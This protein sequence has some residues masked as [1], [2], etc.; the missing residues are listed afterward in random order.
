MLYE[1][2][3]KSIPKFRNIEPYDSLCFGKGE[4]RIKIFVP[5][6]PAVVAYQCGYN[7]DE[8]NLFSL[9]ETLGYLTPK[10]FVEWHYPKNEIESKKT[11]FKKAAW[12]KFWSFFKW[13]GWFTGFPKDGDFELNIRD[14]ELKVVYAL[15]INH[16]KEKAKVI[17]KQ[18]YQLDIKD[19]IVFRSKASF[20]FEKYLKRPE[21]KRAMNTIKYRNHWHFFHHLKENGNQYLSPSRSPANSFNDM[22]GNV[23]HVNFK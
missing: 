18:N 16:K 22:I 1:E 6:N 9:E 13:F 4:E 10:E 17:Y 5:L 11:K 20:E 21:V 19:E 7:T 15:V 23:C 2:L 8:T 14:A 3:V 12:L